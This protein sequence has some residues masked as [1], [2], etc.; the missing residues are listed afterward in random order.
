MNAPAV[1]APW[2]LWVI[3]ILT[4][5][6]NAGGAF[7]W[8][9]THLRAEWYMGQFTPEQLDYFYAFPF[10]AEIFWA[11]VIWGAVIGS[12]G[13]L[14]RKAWTVWAFGLSLLGIAGTSVY[15]F[16][17]SD[18]IALMGGGAGIV[19]F[20]LAIVAV[21]IALYFYARAMRDRGVLR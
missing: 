1:R 11:V 17:L 10:W 5:L 9:M 18:G 20:N 7:D 15:T 12:L 14:L 19:A 8:L 21:A 16:L 3:G 6:W 4:L 2:H 13:L